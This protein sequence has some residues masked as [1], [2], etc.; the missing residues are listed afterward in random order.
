MKQRLPV[1]LSA[2]ALVVA[3]LGVTPLGEAAGRVVRKIPPFAQRANYANVAGNAKALGSHKPS[4][5]ALLG[6]DGKLPAALVAGAAGGQGAKGD[7]G[8]KGDTGTKGDPGPRGPGGLVSARTSTPATN[9]TY[10]VL[11]G[12]TTVASLPCRRA[13]TSSSA[14]YSSQTRVT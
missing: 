10:K 8:A 7:P 4:A 12:S 1:I 14:G 13:V 9:D 5:F 11:T 2:T 3:L 6:A